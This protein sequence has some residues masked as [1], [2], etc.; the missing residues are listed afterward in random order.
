MIHPASGYLLPRV[1]RAGRHSSPRGRGRLGGVLAP[2][3]P[4][5]TRAFFDRSFAL[6]TDQWSGYLSD[7]LTVPEL[8][9]VMLRLFGAAPVGLKWRL[10]RAG[11]WAEGWA[12]ARSTFEAR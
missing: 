10:A 8:R 4:P 5:S 6:P 12:L 3:A 1:H 11:F 2:R 7:R 9:I